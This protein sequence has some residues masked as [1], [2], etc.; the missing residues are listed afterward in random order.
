VTNLI[1]LLIFVAIV[2]I[3]FMVNGISRRLEN[4]N[5]YSKEDAEL[6]SA[7]SSAQHELDKLTPNMQKPT[8]G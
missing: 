8:K 6:K 1:L 5:D 7:T 3:G 4:M 2:A